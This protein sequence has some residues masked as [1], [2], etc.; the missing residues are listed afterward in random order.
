VTWPAVLFDELAHA[1]PEHV[2][3]GRVAGYD[4]KAGFDA[5]AE[6]EVR[7]LRELGLG[8]ESTLVDLGAGTGTLALAAAGAFARVVA[9]DVSP[10]MVAAARAKV[11]ERGVANVE[12]VQA[13]FLTYEHRGGPADAVYSRNA[14]HHLPDF[15]K[16]VALE[17]I[18][19]MLRPG[20]I[21]RLLDIVF[22]FEADEAERR[23]AHWLDN[24]TWPRAELEAHMRDEH[25]TFSWV[26]EQMLE[27]AGFEIAE[28]EYDARRVF[29]RYVCTLTPGL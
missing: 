13:G 21:L 15:W 23:V 16:A 14:L 22:S 5:D 3:A 2:D 17:R 9:V 28:T 27:R 11:A 24:A 19:R 20:G 4:A 1:G 29:A 25:S 7:L 18:A 6:D 8:P 26:L 10:A 12:S